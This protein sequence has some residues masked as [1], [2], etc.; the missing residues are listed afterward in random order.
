M[1]FTDE[2]KQKLFGDISDL[3]DIRIEGK[4]FKVPHYLELLRCLQFLEFNIACEHFCWN[5]SCENCLT[6]IRHSDGQEEDV[7]LCQE[8]AE[9]NVEILALPEGVT[10]NS[11]G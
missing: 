10:F 7:L 11:E 9:E 3:I 6:H 8:L 5:A 2:Q 4:A 1:S